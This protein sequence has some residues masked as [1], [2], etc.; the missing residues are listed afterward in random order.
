M[1]FRKGATVVAADGQKIGDVER[2]VLEP[3]TREV[4]HI[5][6]EKGTLLTTAKV[7]PINLVGAAT[8]DGLT[9]REAAGDLEALPDFEESHYVPVGEP[10]DDRELAEGYTQS[11]LWVPPVGGLGFGRPGRVGA[12]LPDEE[13]VVERNI[14]QGTVALKEGAQV[15]SQDGEHV[16]DVEEILTDPQQDQVT[17]VVISSGLLLK[18]EKLVP[19]T[20]ISGILEDAVTLSVGSSLLEGL[21][22]YETP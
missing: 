2:V 1:Q 6:V 12:P 4:T 15:Y 14:P 16:G 5:V 8:E 11:L 17:H 9:L 20:W 13:R 22:T 19:A 7:L 3:Q 18:E 21:P 10:E